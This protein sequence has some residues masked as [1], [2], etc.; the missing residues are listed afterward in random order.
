MGIILLVVMCF[1]LVIS[2]C[3]G[4]KLEGKVTAPAIQECSAGPKEIKV[5]ERRYI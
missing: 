5:N 3:N 2:V 1:L 4:V